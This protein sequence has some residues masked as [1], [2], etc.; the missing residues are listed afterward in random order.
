MPPASLTTAEVARVLGVSE[1]RVRAFVRA[2]WCAPGRRG[3][4]LAFRFQDL[5]VLRAAKSLHDARVPAAR[6]KRALRALARELGESSE[7]SGLRIAADGKRVVVQRG[8]ARFEPESG[9]LLLEFSASELASDAARVIGSRIATERADARE[10]LRA[11]RARAA[12]R[13]EAARE[14]A[15]DARS[16]ARIAFDEALAHEESCDPAAAIRCYRRALARDASFADAAVNLA[17]LLH[18]AGRAKEAAALYER[19]LALDPR[20]AEVHYNLALALEDTRGAAAAMH[21]YEHA[22]ALDPSFADA[23][24]NLAGLLEAAGKKQEALRHYR[25]YE[26]LTR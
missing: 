16:L 15:P 14:P 2:G 13:E 11:G 1:A 12:A 26:K 23:H 6:V 21:H 8:G 25:A 7:L 22:I 9:Q 10:P 5:V 19:A 20:D 17:R 24:W 18:E 3:R 4:A